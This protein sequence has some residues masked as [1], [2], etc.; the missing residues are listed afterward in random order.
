MTKV[1][2][3]G[4]GIAGLSA[5]WALSRGGCSVEI[6]ERVPFPTRGQVHTPSTAFCATPMAAWRAMRGSCPM[7]SRPGRLCGGISA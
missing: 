1:L 5:A 6:F 2:I 3:V 7:L 4:G